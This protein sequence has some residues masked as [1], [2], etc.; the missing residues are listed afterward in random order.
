MKSLDLYRQWLSIQ[1][2]YAVKKMRLI[3]LQEVST[4]QLCW[5]FWKACLQQL[6]S[7]ILPDEYYLFRNRL[8]H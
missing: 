7:T 8:H 6:A 3:R 5:F 2:L 4:Q 1:N